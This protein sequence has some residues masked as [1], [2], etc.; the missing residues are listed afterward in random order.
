MATK[1][2]RLN[3]LVTFRFEEGPTLWTQALTLMSQWGGGEKRGRNSADDNNPPV[4]QLEDTF[5]FKERLLIRTQDLTLISQWE[6]E[7]REG[8]DQ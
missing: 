4:S 8:F 1:F 2:Q 5:R 6:Q 3:S 7:A